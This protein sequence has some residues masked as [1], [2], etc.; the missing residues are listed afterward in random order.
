MKKFHEWMQEY[1]LTA[2]GDKWV[3]TAKAA[4]SASK[5]KGK[6][7]PTGKK[8]CP[9]CNHNPCSCGLIKLKSRNRGYEQNG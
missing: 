1:A 6:G 5:E 2:K 8:E 3:S 7:I 4:K 9:V